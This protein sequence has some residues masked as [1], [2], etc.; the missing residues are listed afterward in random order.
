[1]EKDKWSSIEGKICFSQKFKEVNT[2]YI[3]NLKIQSKYRKQVEKRKVEDLFCSICNQ[4]V[5][6]APIASHVSSKY[7][8]AKIFRLVGKTFYL[9][10]ICDIYANTEN[11][12]FMKL[13][14]I[15]MK[16]LQFI[17]VIGKDLQIIFA[18]NV[19]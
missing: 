18:L 1:M 16:M 3:D 12:K 11:Q 14:E 6:N 4:I 13:L 2:K 8:F 5:L 19:K 9:C 7:Y 15:N 17:Q 10:I